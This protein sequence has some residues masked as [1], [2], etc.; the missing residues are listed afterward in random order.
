MKSTN[1]EFKG[2]RF[3]GS[4]KIDHINLFLILDVFIN[5]IMSV[6]GSLNTNS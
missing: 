3:F 1:V 4:I 6:M 5:K 2:I